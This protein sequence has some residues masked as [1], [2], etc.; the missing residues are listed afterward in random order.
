MSLTVPVPPNIFGFAGQAFM[1]TGIDSKNVKDG[2]HFILLIMLQW[3][4]DLSLCRVVA[5]N[6]AW[7]NLKQGDSKCSYPGNEC[8]AYS[9]ED[10]FWILR[11]SQ[12]RYW[13]KHL[14]PCFSVYMLIVALKVTRSDK[15]VSRTIP[16]LQLCDC[17]WS[18]PGWVK[19]T[20]LDLLIVI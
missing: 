1:I 16:Q 14:Q 19:P 13:H 8:L 2:C 10:F 15:K 3:K 17:L 12:C 6:S 20:S 7:N 11:Y 18:V 5:E 4:T 9:H